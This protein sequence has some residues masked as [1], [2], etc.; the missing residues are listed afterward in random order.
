[1]PQRHN[2]GMRSDGVTDDS[3]AVD[4]SMTSSGRRGLGCSAQ[5]GLV[6]PRELADVADSA[7][8]RKRSVEAS[9]VRDYPHGGGLEICAKHD[10]IPDTARN[11]VNNHLALAN[12]ALLQQR[13]RFTDYTTVQELEPLHPGVRPGAGTKRT[14]SEAPNG[15]M[16]FSGPQAPVSAHPHPASFT[17]HFLCTKPS[18]RAVSSAPSSPFVKITGGL[19]HLVQRTPATSRPLRIAHFSAIPSGAQ[20]SHSLPPKMLHRSHGA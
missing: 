16:S 2:S 7:H 15:T 14:T 8:E 13:Q 4:N 17:F 18:R 10:S 20:L 9:R 11:D 3:Q 12:S 6:A 19:R 5:N 1:M